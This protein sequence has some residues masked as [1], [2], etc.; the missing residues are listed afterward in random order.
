MIDRV[1]LIEL[2]LSPVTTRASSFCFESSVLF[3]LQ[4]ELDF[5]DHLGLGDFRL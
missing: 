5:W 3:R 1:Q 2:F 4:K